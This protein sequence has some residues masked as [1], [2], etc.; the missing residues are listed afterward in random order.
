MLPPIHGCGQMPVGRTIA[1]FNGPVAEAIPLSKVLVVRCLHVLIL[2]VLAVSILS[3]SSVV[4]QSAFT[5][6]LTGVVSDPNGAVLAN[7]TVEITNE[8]TRKIERSIN[9]EADG[10]YSATLL[11]PGTYS[12]RID[13]S[14]VM[15]YWLSVK[16]PTAENWQLNDP[17]SFVP[18]PVTVP[19][20]LCPTRG[21]RN[22]PP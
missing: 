9:S 22:G 10:S 2:S 18:E 19:H 1:R 11:P 17:G 12:L 5:G 4:A 3:S 7:V 14:Y 6:G 21:I 8:R 16:F 15:V 20:P 13:L